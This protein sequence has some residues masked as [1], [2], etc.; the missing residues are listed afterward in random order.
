MKLDINGTL[1][2]EGELTSYISFTDPTGLYVKLGYRNGPHGADSIYG[3]P[4][5]WLD[6]HDAVIAK[7]GFRISPRNGAAFFRTGTSAPQSGQVVVLAN[8]G[9]VVAAH[10]PDDPAVIGVAM[11]PGTSGFILA[12]QPYSPSPEGTLVALMGVVQCHVDNS[13]FITPI[14]VGDLLTTSNNGFAQKADMTTHRGAVF[15]KAMDGV[16]NGQQK[17]IDVLLMP[18]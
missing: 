1:E 5:L 14:N 17:T 11:D 18:S 10:G 8:D 12:Q 9:T 6:A 2:V 3:Y 15:G 4:N 16:P 7:Q 13:N